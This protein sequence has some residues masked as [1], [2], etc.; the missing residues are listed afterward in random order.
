MAT[1]K[2]QAAVS[3]LVEN[4]GNISKAMKAS[5]YSS[6]TAHTPS[7]LTNSKGYKEIL[8][9]H[10]L[11]TKKVVEA[12][13]QDIDAKPASRAKELSLAID[14]L[15]LKKVEVVTSPPHVSA[16]ALNNPK[17]HDLVQDFEAKI[18]AELTSQIVD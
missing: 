14:L 10:G 12:L 6:K 13:V 7:K 5:G 8:A 9:Q 15:G 16:T 1:Q 18:K 4:G 17:I 11:T 2:Q 3:K